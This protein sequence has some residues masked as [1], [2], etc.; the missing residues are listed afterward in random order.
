[1]AITDHTDLNIFNE[2]HACALDVFRITRTLPDDERYR[3]SDQSIRSSRS[4]CGSIAEAF[5]KRHYRLQFENKILDA[6]AEVAETRVWLAF[7][8]DL[9]MVP[10]EII[11]PLDERY[12][13]LLSRLTN[14]RL[15]APSWCQ[16]HPRK[17]KPQESQG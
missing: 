15:T 9:G 5:R 16:F 7:M 11:D 17:A 1:M 13:K 12:K 6:E 14:T 2:A 3:L 4:P 10:A 8:R